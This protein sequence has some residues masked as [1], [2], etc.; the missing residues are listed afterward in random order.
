LQSKSQDLR[1]TKALNKL[2]NP[3]FV[4]ANIRFSQTEVFSWNNMRLPFLSNASL[5]LAKKLMRKVK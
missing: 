2:V 4:S 3:L 5:Q 1:A